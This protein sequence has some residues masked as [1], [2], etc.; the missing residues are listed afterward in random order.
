[1]SAGFSLRLIFALA[2]AGLAGA[3]CGSPAKTDGPIVVTTPI[4]RK[5]TV[6]RRYTLRE[7]EAGV[8]APRATKNPFEIQHPIYPDKEQLSQLKTALKNGGDVWS[9]EGL[10]SGWAVI[11]DR[12]VIWVL[13]TDHQY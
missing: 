3:G 11:K 6:K 10:D 7:I 8:A 13:V 4:G 9:F 12:A 5:E 2:L 1:V